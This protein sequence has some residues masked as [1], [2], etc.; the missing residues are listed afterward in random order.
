MSKPCMSL[1]ACGALLLTATERT[2]AV[3]CNQIQQ[4]VCTFP[5]DLGGFSLAAGQL[6]TIDFERLPDG[7]PAYGGALITPQFN[8]TNQGVTF[9]P[10]LGLLEIVGSLPG[11]HDLLA[12]ALMPGVVNSIIA[13]FVLPTTAVGIYFPDQTTLYAYDQQGSLLGSVS[14]GPVVTGFM[15]IVADTP[16]AHAVISRGIEAEEIESFVFNPTPEPGTLL[17]LG[18]GWPVLLRRRR[19][20]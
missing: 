2:R 12:D 17:L 6:R 4:P 8:Y 9:S 5:N 18:L 20:V 13:D 3:L 11:N 7:S 19:Y 14:F 1:M 16:I 15:G 10:A